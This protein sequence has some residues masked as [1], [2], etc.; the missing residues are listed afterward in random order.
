[1][2]RLGMPQEFRYPLTRYCLRG[3][4]MTLPRAMVGLF[5]E[6]GEIAALDTR[7]DTEYTLTAVDHRTITGLGPLLK[8]H[9][10]AVNDELVIRPL[11]DGRFAFTAVKRD[12]RPDYSSREELRGVLGRCTGHEPG[13]DG[14]DEDLAH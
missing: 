4:A 1:M 11:E 7:S 10:M 8:Q 13:R 12:H 2:E 14:Q 5:P 3:G 9:R 6:S